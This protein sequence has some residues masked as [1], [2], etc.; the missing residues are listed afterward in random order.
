MKSS[1][2]HILLILHSMAFVSLHLF[3]GRLELVNFTK[4]KGFDATD[5][6]RFHHLKDISMN[7]SWIKVIETCGML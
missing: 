1:N 3:D 4:V 6:Q 5:S 2:S 7:K